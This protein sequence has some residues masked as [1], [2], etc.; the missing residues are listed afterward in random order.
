M[1]P[2]PAPPPLA[3]HPSPAPASPAAGCVCYRRCPH[4]VED[5]TSP[6]L[7]PL[8][9]PLPATTHFPQSACSTT[10]AQAPPGPAA[11][12]AP[13]REA[14]GLLSSAGLTAALCSNTHPAQLA[15]PTPAALHTPLTH[16]GAGCMQQHNTPIAALHTLCAAAPVWGRHYSL[17][18]GATGPAQLVASTWSLAP[19][20][21][22][23]PPHLTQ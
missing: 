15:P 22:M 12:T 20:N 7:P 17:A 4:A 13:G 21:H 11:S 9:R 5:T 3:A 1:P 16:S 6:P 14:E 8:K 19:C 23:T 10:A 2:Q 18:C